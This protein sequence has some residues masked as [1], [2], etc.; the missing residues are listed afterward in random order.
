M[1]G[2]VGSRL[3]TE[4]FCSS[5]KLHSLFCCEKPSAGDRRWGTLREAPEVSAFPNQGKSRAGAAWLIDLQQHQLKIPVQGSQGA[6][7]GDTQLK[8]AGS[9][10]ISMALP[11]GCSVVGWEGRSLRLHSSC[12]CL[13]SFKTGQ[14]LS[15][16]DLKR[17]QSQDPDLAQV[18]IE[19]SSAELWSC[20]FFFPW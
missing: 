18:I 13:L 1:P 4:H 9:L 16:E 2:L 8:E 19:E 11:L 6:G 10:P 12:L 7:G 15:Y 17:F 14:H 20:P 3:Q 5:C